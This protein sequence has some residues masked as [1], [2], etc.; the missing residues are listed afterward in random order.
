MALLCD[1]S[2]LTELLSQEGVCIDEPDEGTLSAIYRLH[3]NV[4]IVV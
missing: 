4:T 1:P 3:V 2:G